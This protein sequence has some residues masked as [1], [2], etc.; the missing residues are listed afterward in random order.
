MN[1]NIIVNVVGVERAIFRLVILL[2][3]RRMNDCLSTAASQAFICKVKAE[4]VY[5]VE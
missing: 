4:L 3:A 2:T 1:N 5:T